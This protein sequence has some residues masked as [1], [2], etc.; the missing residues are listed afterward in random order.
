M[1]ANTRGFAFSRDYLT[2]SIFMWN[3]HFVV[4]ESIIESYA[5]KVASRRCL[6]K[7][8]TTVDASMINFGATIDS[9]A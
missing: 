8:A 2:D 1:V 3:F 9:L 6:L 5:H 4:F 7:A